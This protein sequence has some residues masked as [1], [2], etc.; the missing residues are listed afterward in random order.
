MVQ[1]HQK[2]RH[3]CMRAC[4][5]LYITPSLSLFKVG[6]DGIGEGNSTRAV[7]TAR[8]AVAA[9]RLPVATARPIFSRQNVIC[10][11]V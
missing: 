5:Y 8:L 6:G 10:R 3:H 11:K 1:L 4:V 2:T 9:A 7:A